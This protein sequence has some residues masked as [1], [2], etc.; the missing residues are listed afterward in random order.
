MPIKIHWALNF[1]VAGGPRV[2]AANAIEVDAYDAI[3]VTV[4]K[5]NGADGGTAT[6]AVV[7]AGSVVT[8]LLIHSDVY[9]G[10]KLSYKVGAGSAVKLDAPHTLV[11]AG[12]AGLLDAV[13]AA[14]TFTNSGPTDA[15]VRIL[16][17]RNMP[18]PAAPPPPPP[19][20]EE[21]EEEQQP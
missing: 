2:S 7:P 5:A 18:P 14:I 10:D 21:E 9:D 6:A 4:P 19:P 16:V 17:G 11:G 3:D 20:P 12:A 13:P 1:Q 8:L 15:H